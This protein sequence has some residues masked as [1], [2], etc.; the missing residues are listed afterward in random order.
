MKAL[1]YPLHFGALLALMILPSPDARR[2]ELEVAQGILHR[3]KLN[4]WK[5]KPAWRTDP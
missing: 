5:L 4:A 2:F 3:A 1:I